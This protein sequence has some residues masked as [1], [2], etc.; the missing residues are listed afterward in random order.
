MCRMYADNAEHYSKK[1]CACPLGNDGS[2]YCH[3]MPPP[4]PEPKVEVFQSPTSS[5][6][7][8]KKVAIGNQLKK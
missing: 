3:N 1:F 2:S 7:D 4:F 6:V 8:R 5:K